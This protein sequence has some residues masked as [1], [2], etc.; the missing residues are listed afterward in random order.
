L[1]VTKPQQE[2]QKLPPPM[3]KTPYGLVPKLIMDQTNKIPIALRHRYLKIIYENLKPVCKSAEIACEKAAEQEKS[4]YDRAKTKNTYV[5]LAAHLT[6]KIR[7][8]KQSKPNTERTTR[9][10]V[11]YSHE[12]NLSGSKSAKV[13]YSINRTKPM[14]LNE[15]SRNILLYSLKR[16]F[17][18]EV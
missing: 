16:L 17:K 12:A 7:S 1:S 6:K 8:Q 4:I 3:M 14:T 2:Q 15:L 13:S 9:A 11:S 10:T 5:N 18:I